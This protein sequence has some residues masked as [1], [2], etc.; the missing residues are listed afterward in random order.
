MAYSAD[1][2]IIRVTESVGFFRVEYQRA[3]TL[4]PVIKCYLTKEE[5]DA[6]IASFNNQ[7]TR[8]N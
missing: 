7:P 1:Q 5:A 6:L 2:D 8:S 3:G 4:V